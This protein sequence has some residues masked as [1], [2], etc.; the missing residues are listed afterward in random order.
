MSTKQKTKHF[1]KTH[2]FLFS[3]L[4]QKRG[5]K[6]L[7][8]HS[9]FTFA[10]S[11]PGRCVISVHTSGNLSSSPNCHFSRRSRRSRHAD[12]KHGFYSHEKISDMEENSSQKKYPGKSTTRPKKLD[13]AGKGNYCSIPKCKRV[14]LLH[15]GILQWFPLTKMT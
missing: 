7:K 9:D 3:F 15:W 11:P 6:Y 2:L 4:K 5:K 14:E 13:I 10:T 12:F 8:K 1:Y